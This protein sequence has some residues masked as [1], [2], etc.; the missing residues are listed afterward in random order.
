MNK[1]IEKIVLQVE[2]ELE[3]S[4]KFIME[5]DDSIAQKAYYKGM[6]HILDIINEEAK[7]YNEVKTNG[8][9]IRNM[10]DDELAEFLEQ[11]IS[12]KREVIGIKCGNYRC[13]SWKC[14]ECICTWL[15]AERES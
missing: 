5:Y 7:A 6:S 12:G 15:K 11:V 10:T 2:A 14:T 9:R 4:A 13:E 3:S 8:Q 1:L